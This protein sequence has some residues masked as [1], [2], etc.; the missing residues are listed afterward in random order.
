MPSTSGHSPKRAVFY[1]R[2]STE[3]QAKMGYSI[4]EQLKELRAYAAREDYLVVEEPWA[5][6]TAARTRTVPGCGA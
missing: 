6:V 2:V 5:T 1:V 4:P 3:E